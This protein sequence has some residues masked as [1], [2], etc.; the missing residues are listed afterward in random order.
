MAAAGVRGPL[1]RTGVRRPWRRTGLVLAAGS[2]ALAGAVTVAACTNGG[3]DQGD[4]SAAADSAVTLPPVVTEDTADPARPV[5]PL[6]GLEV[7]DVA[8]AERPAMAVKVGNTDFARPQAGIVQADVVF[9]EIVEAGLTRLVAVYQSTIPPQIGPIRSARLTDISVVFPFGQPFFVSSGGNPVTVGAVEQTGLTD[10]S[11]AK[12]PDAFVRHDDRE[13]PD[14]LYVLSEAVYAQDSALAVAP[15]P[16]L[17]HR[18]EGVEAGGGGQVEGVEVDYGETTVAFAWDGD[19]GVWRREQNGSPHVDDQGAQVA[20]QNV[21]VQFVEYTPT[22]QVDVNG[23]TVERAVLDG[24]GGEAW[25]LTDGMLMEGTW[26][27]GNFTNPTTFT[28]SED[29]TILLT[30]GRTWVLLAEPGTAEVLE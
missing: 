21:I 2:A 25:V 13:V 16:V 22:D 23:T 7:D 18:P 5:A 28:S 6:L 30:P 20:P 3:D 12:V 8:V 17:F 24:T 9:E 1:R 15:G 19:D 26:F 14:D 29:E 4:A 10:V 11:A 27:K